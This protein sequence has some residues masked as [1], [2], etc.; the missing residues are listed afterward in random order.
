MYE[1]DLKTF[2]RIIVKSKKWI[3][4]NCCIAM[5]LAIAFSIPKEYSASVSL[6]S[7]LQGEENI[8]GGLGSL[9]SM[10]GINFNSGGGAIVPILYPDV[11]YSNKFLVRLS[12]VRVKSLQGDIDTDYFSYLKSHTRNPWWTQMFG[13]V[14]KVK[15]VIFPPEDIME[16]FTVLGNGKINPFC[17]SAEDAGVLERM[18][19]LIII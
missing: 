16:N 10:A 17:M 2:V 8:A 3:I 15:N 1:F 18:R 6:A 11:V 13:W 19:F 4:I 9:A 12:D 5:G 14:D 7:E